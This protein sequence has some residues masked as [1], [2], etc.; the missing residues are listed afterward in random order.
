M[1]QFSNVS[2]IYPNSQRTILENLNF[3]VE[4]GELVLVIGLTGAGKSSFIK[5]VNGLIPHHTAGILSGE[6]LI[7][8]VSTATLKPGALSKLIGIVGQNP[9]NSFVTEDV[10]SEIVF[11]LELNELPPA[12]IKQRLSEMIDLL[13][14]EKIRNRKLHDLSGG[15]QQRVAL[16]CALAMQPKMLLLDEPT[17]ALDPLAA[18]EILAIINRLVSDLGLTVIITEH[19]LER[20]IQFVDRVI[21]VNGDGSISAGDVQTVLG[22]SE[23]NPPLIKLAKFFEMTDLPVTVR[24]FRRRWESTYARKFSD[25]LAQRSESARQRSASHT[26]LLIQIQNLSVAY[27]S[28][29]VLSNFNFQAFRGQTIGI[30]GRNG[31]GK[32]TLLRTICGLNRQVSGSVQ[33][34]GQ[35]PREITPNQITRVFGYVPQQPSDL[36]IS[37][38]VAL[39]CALVD[40]QNQLSEGTT[41]GLA[42]K[43]L[44]NL[45]GNQHPRDLSE[46]QKLILVLAIV[47][48]TKPEILILDEPTRGVDYQTK[49]KIVEILSSHQSLGGL[50]LIASHDVELIAQVANRAILISDG[51]LIADDSVHTLLSGSSAFAPTVAKLFPNQKWLTVNDVLEAQV[52]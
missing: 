40:K 13:G 17:S 24:E 25:R 20:V 9:I 15:E 35:D 46:G 10:E 30:L 45:Q 32:S 29:P 12:Q 7:E 33:V 3:K 37:K 51:E 27:Q 39:E 44:S 31:A 52:G 34:L 14:L 16:A 43:F 47:L 22:K 4:P 26:E 28:L 41:F 49:S 21:Q 11:T 48:A 50:T 23:L 1:I 18:E 8:G 38:T 2:L 36:L 6:I 19:R 42:Q 5:L